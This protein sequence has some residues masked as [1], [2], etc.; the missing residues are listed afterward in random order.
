VIY[1][2]RL[3]E[4]DLV[5]ESKILGSFTF[6]H[7][8]VFWRNFTMTSPETLNTKVSVNKL[9][10]LLVTHTVLF[11]ERFDSYGLLKTAH[12]AEWFWSER[13]CEWISQVS[14]HKK[15]ESW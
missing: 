14:G 6:R 13:A 4:L 5:A 10:F 12:G 11:D 8:S 2:L 3:S 9:S 7:K 15:R 1:E